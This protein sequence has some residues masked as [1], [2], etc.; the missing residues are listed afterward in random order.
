MTKRK[1]PPKPIKDA[2]FFK[3]KE[4]A[5]YLGDAFDLCKGLKDGSVNL[6]MTSPPYAL[7]FKKEYGNAT[8]AEYVQWFLR[9]ADDFF[10]VL[11]DDGSLVIDIGG[12][13]TPGKPTRSLY[14]FELLIALCH[15]VGFHLAQEFYWYNPAKLPAP[16]EWV[17]V[18]KIRVKDS[19][20]C[21]WWLSKTD[22]PKADNRKVLVEYSADMLRLMKRGYRAKTRPSGH[23]ITDK[24]GKDQGGA[25]P[26][27]ILIYGNNDANGNYMSQCKAEGIKPHPARFPIQLPT[28]FIRYLTDPGDVVL[29]P[30]AGS[31]TTGEAA[32]R[33]GRR[34][35]A[36]E[37]EE[38]YLTA[39]RFRF[40][41]SAWTPV[42]I[43]QRN[44]EHG[45]AKAQQALLFT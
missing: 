4:G 6:I 26:S 38:P 8:Q 33:D 35:L 39:G 21:L 32:E 42:D 45:K 1:R 18:R 17:T 12:A 7:H 41:K 34:W 25:I 15:K 11:T 43:S 10:R 29:D 16:A 20:N 14:H 44:G 3:T 27:N 5:A 9:F 30:F 22:H 37:R 23:V 28:F 19:V 2:P 24:F 31:L 40:D 13:W 36:F